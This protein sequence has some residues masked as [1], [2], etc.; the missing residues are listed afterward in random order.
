MSWA[1]VPSQAMKP[2][3]DPTSVAPEYDRV[4]YSYDPVHSVAVCSI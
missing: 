1:T 3:L 2:E 4:E